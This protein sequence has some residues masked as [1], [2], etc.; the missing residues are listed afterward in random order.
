MTNQSLLIRKS[1][2]FVFIGGVLTTLN[3]TPAA[4]ISF[5]PSPIYAEARS[6]TTEIPTTGSLTES[7][8]AEIYFPVTND[9]TTF[10][11][12]LMLQGAL[13]ERGDYANFAAQV[14]RYGFVVVVPDHQRTLP[15][16]MGPIT[17]LFPDVELV[18]DVLDF[19]EGENLN[20]LSDLAGKVN[21]NQMGLLGHSFGGVVGLTAIQGICFPFLCND[22][23]FERPE[24][25][26]AGIFYGTSFTDQ[27]TGEFLPI[28]NQGIPTGLIAGE[29]DGVAELAE[30]QETYDQIQDPPKALVTVLGANHY[31]ITNDDSFRDP[32]RPTLPQELATETIARWSAL[33][34]R[35]HVQGDGEAFD[36]IYNSGEAQDENVTVVSETVPE[37]SA[38][39]GIIALGLGGAVFRLNG[40]KKNSRRRILR[41]NLQ[42]RD[43]Q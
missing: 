9:S 36:Y 12:A 21:T 38:T 2:F 10:P 5:D 17:G 39:W 18:D 22:P 31:G 29:L 24:E 25:L 15:G 20:D 3:S 28:D 43:C 23:S 8:S 35:A 11:L 40:Q 37:A 4:A 32:T 30:V 26:L 13:V 41:N 7:D 6:Y 34:L 16:P 14:A 1:I 27:M 19:M 33:F 42:F